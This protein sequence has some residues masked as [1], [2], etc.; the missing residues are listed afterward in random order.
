[1]YSGHQPGLGRL[2]P[3]FFHF[4]ILVCQIRHCC[5]PIINKRLH[6]ASGPC[7][8]LHKYVFSQLRY[9]LND[10]PHCSYA[11]SEQSVFLEKHEHHEYFL[12]GD[13]TGLIIIYIK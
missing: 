9:I 10:L 4:T 12:S 1:M 13:R 6:L 5:F 2:S 7:C 11:V 8:S 3:H